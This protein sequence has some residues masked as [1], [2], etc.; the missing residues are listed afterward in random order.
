MQDPR[1]PHLIAAFHLLRYLKQDPI[2]G[3]HISND[4]DRTVQAF[5]DS[6]WPSCPDSK[7][8][9]SGYLVLLGNSP[10][11]WKVKKEETISLSS[12]E[13]E[14]RSLRK[15]VGELTWLQR[16]LDELTIHN[17]SPIDIYCDSQSS[18]HITHNLCSM[19]EP[20]IL[21]LTSTL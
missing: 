20:S 3:V 2:Q 4:P 8:S 14:Y 16:L 17:S 7:R 19:R 5:C 18:R 15:V 13:A 12:P 1:T 6:D 11:S 9:V 10:T 21:K